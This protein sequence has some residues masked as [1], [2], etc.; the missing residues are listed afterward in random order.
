MAV[1]LDRLHLLNE[2][3]RAAENIRKLNEELE[4]RVAERTRQLELA[5]RELEHSKQEIQ[6]LFDSMTTLNAQVAPDGR[7]LLVNRIAVQASGLSLDELLNTNFL[8][9]P[10]WGFDPDVQR[11]VRN[12]FAEA[13]AGKLINYDEKI[14]VFG[15]VLTINFSLTP[16]RGTD[17]QVEYILAEGRD[18]TKQK[19]IEQ[20]LQAK[21]MQLEAAN[22][23]LDAFSHSVSHDLRA[24]LR[25]IAGF[26]EA[27]LEDFGR[28]LPAEGRNYLE[29][30]R[31]A[32]GH[33]TELIDAMLNLSRLTRAPMRQV[34]VDLSSLAAEIVAEL[35][36]AQPQRKANVRIASGLIVRGDPHLL[37]AVLQ[38][39]LNNA[40]KYTS[41]REQ[42]EIELG[43]RREN[44]ETIYFIRDN[45]AGFDMAYADKLFAAFQRLHGPDDFPGTGVGLATV[46]RII[47]RHGGRIWAEAEVDRGATFFFSLP[48]EERRSLEIGPGT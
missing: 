25:A 37:Q 22:L 27:L 20:A 13:C 46:R 30:V 5:N 48:G 17:G 32:A 38:N 40:W 24:P 10:W 33:M 4:E 6:H 26:T 45:G 18:I 29:R 47:Q 21:T 2:R 15:Q 44:D 14:F 34:A 23:E 42:A 19:E 8:E 39:L 7:L 16:M 36:A 31:R 3:R 12:A 41:R 35:H 11:R 9:G 28:Q 1:T 43:A